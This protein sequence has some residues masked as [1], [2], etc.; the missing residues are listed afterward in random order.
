MLWVI[1]ANRRDLGDT[2]VSRE[3][4]DVHHEMNGQSDRLA[5]IAMWQPDVRRQDTMSQA[6]ERL[7]R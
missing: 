2:P 3:S 4:R 5:D 7:L 1:S 6:R